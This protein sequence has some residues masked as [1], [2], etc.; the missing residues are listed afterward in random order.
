MSVDSQAA[1]RAEAIRLGVSEAH[2]DLLITKGIRTHSLFAFISSYQPGASDEK[3]FVDALVA[4]LGEEAKDSLPAFR[5]LF[6]TSHT[7]AVQ[8]LKDKLEP[9]EEAK[10]LSMAD[11][12]DRLERLKKALGVTIDTWL[13]PSH[14]LV[15]KAVG[16]AEE[17]CLGPLELSRCTSREAEMRSEKRDAETFRLEKLNIK[18]TKLPTTLTAD[19]STDLHVRTCMQRRALAFHMAGIATFV[20][21]DKI[22]S[23]FFGFMMRPVYPGQQPVTLSQVV[24]ADRTLWVLVAQETRGKV[25]TSGTPLPIDAAVDAFKDAP[26]VAFAL[27]PRTKG[28][29][30]PPPKPSP[31]AGAE[32]MS[33]AKRRRL[34]KAAKSKPIADSAQPGKPSAGG[35]KGGGKGIDIPPGAKTRDDQGRPI[36]F[37]CNRK[38]CD[39]SKEKC[40]RGYHVCWFC[41]KN[42]AGAIAFGPEKFS[43]VGHSPTDLHCAEVLAS[44]FS[45][46]PTA[47]QL[48]SLLDVLPPEVPARGRPGDFSWTTGSWSKDGCYG[49]RRHSH[50]FPTV[51]SALTAY[52]RSI[53]P[54]HTFTAVALFADLQTAPHRDVNNAVGAPNLLLPLT[55]FQEG[56]VW[57]YHETGPSWQWVEG[58]H[59]PGMLLD[60]SRGPCYLDSQ[61]LH[62]TLPWRGK[63][64]LVV[65]FTPRCDDQNFDFA[66]LVA[67]GFNVGQAGQSPPQP[68]RQHLELLGFKVQLPPCDLHAVSFSCE[69]SEALAVEAFCGRGRLSVA[70]RDQGLSVLPVDHRVRC[71]DLQ[72]LRLDLQDDHDASIFLEMLS[73]A[74]VCL[75]HFGPP[76]GTS[77]KARELPLP[78]EL[79]HLQS[80]PLRSLASPFGLDGLRPSQAARVHSANKLY[81]LTLVSIW[82]LHVRGALVSCE[83]PSSSLFWRVADLLAQDLPDPAAWQVLEDVAFHACMWGSTRNKRTTF[84]ATPGLCSGLRRDCDGSHEHLSW[85]P[86]ATP[87]GVVF[88]TSGEAEYTKELAAAY[89]A[90]SLRALQLRG[91]RTERSHVGP[92]VL[93]P[94]D[95]RSF[96][97]KRVPPLLAEYWLVAPR[98]CVPPEWPQR[99]L[100]KHVLFPKTGDEVITVSSVAEVRALEATNAVKPSTLVALKALAATGAE[101][102]VGVLRRPQQT[103]LATRCLSHPLELNLPLPDILVKAVVNVLR[104]GPRGI[105]FHRAT[106]LQKLLVRAEALK[107][108][109]RELHCGLHPDLRKVL[110][111][112]NTILWEQL[113]RESHF[114]DLGLVDEVRGGFE[115]VGPANCSGAFPMAYKPPQQSVEKLM[116]Q[117]VWR[118]KNTISKCKPTGDTAADDELWSQTLGE[119]EQGWIDGPYWAESEVSERLGSA[120]WMC[121]RRFPIVQGPKV[122]IIDDCLQS[123]LNSAYAAY[124]K[125]R[126]MDADA[127]ISLVLLLIRCSHQPGSMIQ[128]DSGEQLVVKRHPEWGDGLDLLGKTLDLSAAYK[129][130][131]C[132]PYTKFNRVLVAWSPERRAPAFFVSTALMFGASSAVFSFNRCSASL[133]HLA[134]TMGSV[135][136]TVYFDDFPCAEPS[137]SSGSAQDFMVGLLSTCLGW[138]VALQP[139]KNQPFSQTFTLLGIELSLKTADQGILKVRNKPDRVLELRAELDRLLSQG[140]M[141]RSEASSLHGRLNFAQGQ[142]HGCPIKPAL[143][144]LSQVAANGWDDALADDFKLVIGY[145]A[146]C[147]ATDS[148]RVIHALDSRYAI[149]LFTDGAWDN[150]IA[151]AGAVLQYALDQGPKVAEVVVPECLIEHW[152]RHGGTQLISQLELFPVLVSLVSWGPQLAGRRI[153]A[154]IDNNGVRDSLIKGSSP[155]P[156]HFVMLSMI[157]WVARRY[158]FTLWF[159]RVASESNPA[160]KPSRSQARE[161]AEELGGS[162]ELPLTLDD[163]LVKGLLS[164]RSFMDMCQGSMPFGDGEN[165]GERLWQ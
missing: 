109:E 121:T 55:E 74:N 9:R 100:P 45:S 11:R 136:C 80:S 1:F 138:N 148:P 117:A 72:V 4:K 110:A 124:N 96:T 142:L 29:V 151:G 87:S 32:A 48:L 76:C 26:D 157:A 24:D 156:D 22:I 94:R 27:M 65:A 83:N 57:Q 130:L 165:V 84:R 95:L 125:L 40:Q 104:V 69:A 89:A 63:R 106:V 119:V 146:A 16:F 47:K 54:E 112:K 66:Q 149:K 150:R 116:Q 79:S 120:E 50:M 31:T 135:C 81:V 35:S 102:M 88:P 15:D 97:R 12:V 34:Q 70:L 129:Q 82:I 73:T 38:A 139:K 42:H 144:F 118:R 75:A 46:P 115:L 162:L 99:P 64:V 71:T 5:H 114:P 13:E 131:G 111:G 101:P 93:R 49:L 134:V 33:R 85:T 154:F 164:K 127:F 8:E 133:W 161:A 14:S 67:L 92:G 152:G 137:A 158:H 91:L 30:P 25:L 6:Y 41:L 19:T 153:L 107:D 43:A 23:R 122:R 52:V 60:V 141:K 37:R 78:P 103:V 44:S 51:T 113:L 36:C 68:L 56:Q 20:V 61:A 132:R 2:A 10:R 28:S 53:A 145:I 17:G 108:R 77:S 126:L 86:T 7:L 18:V 140:Y 155:L 159:T 147:F 123:G 3:P 39:Q 62:F 21:L 98:D 90:F 105:A 163:V 160:D 58:R 143:K 59:L 128:L